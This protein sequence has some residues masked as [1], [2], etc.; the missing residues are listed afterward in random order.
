MITSEQVSFALSV[1]SLSADNQR[2][3]F[4]M[5][6]GVLT[7]AEIRDLQIVVAYFRLKNNPYRENAMKSAMASELYE[8]FTMQKA[9]A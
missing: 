4:R 9:E 3:F 1:G 2:I 5:L 6:E 7:D 8:Y